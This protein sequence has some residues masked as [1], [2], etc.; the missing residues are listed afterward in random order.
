MCL[1][2]KDEIPTSLKEINNSNELCQEKIYEAIL[3]LNENIASDL[4][5][6]NT[7]RRLAD[8]L[9][10]KVKT[11]SKDVKLK[12]DNLVTNKPLSAAEKRSSDEKV[13]K[14]EAKL[15]NCSI[16]AKALI[17]K[18][19]AHKNVESMSEQEIRQALMEWK[20]EW[21][22]FLEKLQVK[23]EELDELIFDVDDD[24]EKLQ[25]FRSDYQEAIDTVN[26][27][28]KLL[29]DKDKELGLYVLAP[30]KSKET[31]CY[32]KIF[33]GQRGENV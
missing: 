29:Q 16:R 12:L 20:D 6:I 2:L 5:K 22:V 24:T 32:P 9:N 18:V 17:E 21:K 23:K 7:L 4:E 8:E 15:T 1:N 10:V 30:N 13:S 25:A 33:T 11:N 27:K 19:N 26:K 3:S 14:L 31:I 28:V